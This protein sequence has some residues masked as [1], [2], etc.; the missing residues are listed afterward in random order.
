MVAQRLV[1]KRKLVLFLIFQAIL[2]RVLNYITYY[3][4]EKRC[5][6]NITDPFSG[7]YE[8]QRA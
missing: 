3:R 7:K 4:N 2:L 8:V 1:K 5:S 6:Y